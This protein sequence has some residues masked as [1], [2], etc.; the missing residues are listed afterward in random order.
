M[1]SAVKSLSSAP[2]PPAPRTRGHQIV[3]HR[4]EPAAEPYCRSGLSFFK[5]KASLT[6]L[7]KGSSLTL[8]A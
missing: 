5:W 8:R 1:G 2:T 4:S 6:I 7:S 3:N